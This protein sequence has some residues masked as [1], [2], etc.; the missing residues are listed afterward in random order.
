M[1]GAFL[2]SVFSLLMAWLPGPPPQPHEL[3]LSSSSPLPLPQ[4]ASNVGRAPPPR[5]FETQR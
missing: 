4:K 1:L 2:P 5:H 3:W